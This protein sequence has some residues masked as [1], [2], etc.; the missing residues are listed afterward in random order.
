MVEGDRGTTAHFQ[1]ALCVPGELQQHGRHCAASWRDLSG[2]R[3]CAQHAG[4][5]MLAAGLSRLYL[6]SAHGTTYEIPLALS[7]S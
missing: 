4:K 1:G 7:F 6:E 5:S 2:S 3:A